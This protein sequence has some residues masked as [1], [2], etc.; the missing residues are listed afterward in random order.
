MQENTGTLSADKHH[1]QFPLKLTTFTGA[2]PRIALLGG[3]PASRM[4]ATV[5]TTQFG[6]RALASASLEDLTGE[7]LDTSQ[8]DLILIDLDL[9]PGQTRHREPLLRMLAQS[10][11][12]PR[13]ALAEPALLPDKDDAELGYALLAKPYSPRELYGAMAAAMMH[14]A[15]DFGT[16]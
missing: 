2:S 1:G 11:S 13:I 16:S 12:V 15:P 14:P 9:P 10:Q 6:C 4:V 3:S 8:A 7:P 5:L